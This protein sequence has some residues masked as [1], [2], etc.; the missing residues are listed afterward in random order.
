[1]KKFTIIFAML[2]C[3]TLLVGQNDNDMHF[4]VN[5]KVTLEQRAKI[6]STTIIG[7]SIRSARGNNEFQRT[8]N[9]FNK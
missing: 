7:N 1:M 8:Y 4:D 5:A 2:F 3:T 9:I 6:D